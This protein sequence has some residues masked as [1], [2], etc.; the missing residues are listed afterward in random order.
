MAN[1]YEW[2]KTVKRGLNEFNKM[3][4]LKGT[5]LINTWDKFYFIFFW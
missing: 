4:H 2:V 1:L 3:I 5:A